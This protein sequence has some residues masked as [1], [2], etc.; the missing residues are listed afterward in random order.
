MVAV[1]AFGVEERGTASH[2]GGDGLPYLVVFLRKD[3][4]LVRLLVA[5]YHHIKHIGHR[6]HGNV[7]E[8]DVLQL[9]R[10]EIRQ[11]DDD[12]VEIHNDLAGGDIVELGEYQRDNV[13][14]TTVAAHGEGQTYAAATYCTADDG[15]HKSTELT[16][17][18]PVLHMQHLLPK[19]ERQR[20]HHYAENGLD[21][22]LGSQNLKPDGQ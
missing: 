2:L 5:I 8:N 9:A 11:S 16:D 21:A 17:I 3:H 1:A 4:N 22:E 13:G 6:H 14:T 19:D 15:T 20:R 10:N 7:T 18:Q 12:N